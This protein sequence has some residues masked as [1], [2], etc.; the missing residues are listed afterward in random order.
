MNQL[1]QFVPAAT[2]LTQL[3]DQ[4]NLTDNDPT[5]TAGAATI[6]L[7]GLGTNRNLVLIDGYRAVPVNAT[8][9]VDIN[10]IP[11][12]AIQRVETITGG[13]SSVYGADAVAGVVNF[14][15][16]KN[17]QGVNIDAQYGSM[18]NGDA[19][20]GHISAL[21]G[22]NTADGKGNIMIGVERS[23]RAAVLGQDTAFYKHAMSDPTVEGTAFF[24]TD[25]YYNIDTANAPSGAVIDNIFNQAPAGVVLRNGAGGVTGRAYWNND[26]TIYTGGASFNGGSPEGPGSTVGVYRYNGPF[27]ITQGNANLPGSYPWRKIDAQ[28]RIQE[29]MPEFVA[30]IPLDRTSLF[31]RA[32]YNLTDRVQAFVQFLGVT[33]STD[34]HTLVSPALGG[35]GVMVPH[36]TDTYAPSLETDG[37]TNPDYLQGGRFGLNCAPTGGCTNSQVWP[38]SPELGQLLDS[39]PNPN[40]DFSFNYNLDFSDWGIP[41]YERQIHSATRSQQLNFGLEGDLPGI[42]GTWNLVVSKGVSKM[43]AHLNGMASLARVRTL[44]TSPNWGTGF[45]QQ[46]NAGD[47]GG[48][49]GGGFSGGVATCTSGIPTFRN[50]SEITQDCLDTIFIT[51]QEQSQM[52]QNFVELDFQGHLVNLP[53]GEARF[54]A[55]ATTRSNDYYYL[56]DSLAGDQAF[57][58]NLM[59]TNLGNNTQGS[60]SVKELYGEMLLPMIKD[61]PGADHLN[62]ELGY[63]YSDYKI[64]GG[65]T[66][67]K[68]LLDWGITKS[69][70]FRGGKQRATRAPNI[71]EM[72]QAATQNWYVSGTGDPC[73]LNSNAT[74]GAN[75][76]VNPNYQQAIALCSARMGPVGAAYFYDPSTLQ[77]NGFFST[78]FYN[79]T[80][81]PKVNPETATTWTAGFV[82]QPQSG[83][84]KLDALNLTVDYYSID[85]A[86]MISVEPVEVVYEACLSAAS[87]PTADPTTPACQQI[88]RNPTSGFEAPSRVTYVNAAFAKVQGVDFTATWRT[89]LANGTFGINF[90]ITD[91]LREETQATADSPIYDWTGSLGPTPG[92]SLTNGAYNYRTFTT[93][94]YGRNL[95]NL[96]MRWRHLPSALDPTQVVSPV[97][98]HVGAQ[99]SYDV[100][101]L[102][103]AWN[104]TAKTTVRF[105]ITNLFD[106]P[107]VWTGGR[108]AADNH[109]STGSGQ[110]EAGFY[111]LLGRQFYLG[112]NVSF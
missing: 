74:Y 98:T 83:R 20:E 110:T 63:R 82:W 26:G 88:F 35:W 103:G 55:G 109:P 19:G 25:P 75:K 76:N 56:F 47:Y 97:S 22:V 46:G 61:K 59:A 27:N 57:T 36:G 21:F 111:D 38:V 73:G 80:G 86:D 95:W 40:A 64:Q 87:N 1:P 15:T 105:G 52:E 41:D 62:L 13:A 31:G 91:L 51:A 29:Q 5:I 28:G 8:M 78:P 17:F 49:Q 77:P 106:A 92:T 108:T 79:A 58:D 100:F 18:Q 37:T 16:R 69:L 14:I 90:M 53:A 2:G 12:A 43:D 10:S 33:S 89:M 72:F 71:A 65:V 24:E 32:Q 96:A 39:R 54:S 23:K 42:D 30:N 66:T 11:S 4:A 34:R 60:T 85:V 94:S 68:A 9:A 99:Q 48:G 6:S 102:T 104:A 93:F 67:W 81:N 84:E 70:R 3:Q 112:A 50:H 107:P 101:D 44:L 7:R 45:Y